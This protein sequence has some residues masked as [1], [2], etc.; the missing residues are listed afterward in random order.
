MMAKCI[1]RGTKWG[2]IRPTKLHRRCCN[3]RLSAVSTLLARCVYSVLLMSS[4]FTVHQFN[5]NNQLVTD[6]CFKHLVKLFE[7]PIHLRDS[8]GIEVLAIIYLV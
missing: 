2:E 6:S 1:T 3:A 5:V 8:I 7:L 4:Y